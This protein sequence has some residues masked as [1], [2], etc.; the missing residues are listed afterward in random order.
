MENKYY[1]RNVKVFLY[2]KFFNNMLIIGPVLMLFLLWKGLSYTNI[3]VLQSL[4]A[5]SVLLF[6]VPTGIVSDKITRHLALF[7]GSLL[8]FMGLLLYILGHCF[9]V[10]AVAEIVFG[11]GMTFT[12]GSD[13]SLLYESLVKLDRK[14]EYQTILGKSM[15]IMFIGQGIGAVI[16]SLLYKINP[17]IPFIISLGF[18]IVAMVTSTFFKDQGRHKSTGN[19]LSH[20]IHSGREV[21]TKKRILW[22]LGF[23]VIMGIA[24]RCSFWL[25]QPYFE[26]IKLDVAWF[27]VAF[28]FFN[29]AAASS[30][31]YLVKKFK[32][33]R[34][35]RLLLVLLF[36]MGISFLVPAL[37]P[38]IF[39]IPVFALQ[40]F[41]RGLYNP[42]MSF[43][44][45]HQV[46][47]HNR[48][49]VSS[50]VSM[51]ACLGF[52][53]FSPISGHWLDT[54]GAIPT[55]FRMTW[56]SWSGFVL[57]FIF[58]RWHKLAKK[59]K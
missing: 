1:K 18:L 2:Y 44:I 24:S 12:S 55:Y 34:P 45:N 20:I 39:L 56:F 27:G 47:D 28:L 19:Y 35:R 14:K 59:K 4:S 15:S 58:W 26:V 48:A 49:T 10:F 37:H 29:I 43:Y 42:T 36:I 7:M 57:L 16:S 31:H 30:S 38:A 22:A 25:Y 40:Q 32:D 41:V 21:F 17:L 51:A 50:M 52:A 54:I 11:L 8:C 9:F 5:L 13:T 53:I 33:V 3:M 46:E 23:A 6:E